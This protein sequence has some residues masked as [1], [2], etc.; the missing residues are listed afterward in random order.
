LKLRVETKLPI[1]NIVLHHHIFKN[2]GSS[3]D[4][5]LR[6]NLSNSW[7]SYEGEF[8]WSTLS[9]ESIISF[10]KENPHVTAVSSHQARPFFTDPV[11]YKILPIIFLR[12]PI[13]RA[14]SCYDYER[15]QNS[16]YPS[17]IAAQRGESYYVD[18]CLDDSNPDRINA[19]RNFQTLFLSSA[20]NT[21]EDS[22]KV[23]ACD[24]H[25]I[26]AK[27][28]LD[29]LDF[30]GLVEKFSISMSILQSF[31]GPIF[32]N[33]IFDMAVNA[34]PNRR[35]NINARMTEFEKK[36]GGK[37]FD[38]LVSENFLDMQLYQ[39]ASRRFDRIAAASEVE[40]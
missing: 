27:H 31:L 38:R 5:F 16:S 19:F 12:N 14:R 35:Q 32:G 21:V 29:S 10:L 18:F 34:T 8:P 26:E 23:S 36:L 37:R 1:K 39:Y 6:E 11:G 20:L 40:A 2:S 13:D 15:L 33:T 17:S 28:F 30:L 4:H 9:N 7:T 24:I 22:R 25:L 3:I